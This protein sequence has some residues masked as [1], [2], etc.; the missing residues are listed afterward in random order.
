M[1]LELAAGKGHG[2]KGRWVGKGLKAPWRLRGRGPRGAG[3]ACA[4]VG[5]ASMAK[6]GGQE[7]FQIFSEGVMGGERKYTC[8]GTDGKGS[9]TER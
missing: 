3:S 6:V 4:V 5:V 2:G 8:V 7:G 1:V 9:N